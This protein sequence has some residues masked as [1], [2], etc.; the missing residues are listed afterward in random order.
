MPTQKQMNRGAKYKA[1]AAYQFKNRKPTIKKEI[2]DLVK[3]PLGKIKKDLN[4]TTQVRR[5]ASQVAAG[6]PIAERKYGTGK[7]TGDMLSHKYPH[8]VFKFQPDGTV[9]K[10]LKSYKP[11]PKLKSGL[12]EF[13]K[14]GKISKYYASGGNVITGRD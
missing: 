8:G 12:S 6:D 9:E 10:P 5:R 7:R 1:S 2:M 3:N 4:T 14:G 11:N 13:N